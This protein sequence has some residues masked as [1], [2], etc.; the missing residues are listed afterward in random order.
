MRRDH[1]FLTVLAALLVALPVSLAGGAA[2]AA[3]ADRSSEGGVVVLAT[4]GS[5]HGI[6]AGT[7]VAKAGA[8]LLILTAAHVATFGVLELRLADASEVPARLVSVMPGRDLALIEAALPEN[9]AAQLQA[10]PLARPL[11]AEVVHVWGSGNDGPA[12]ETGTVTSVGRNL[13]D[14]APRGRYAFGCALCHEGDSGAGLFNER[15]ELVGVYIGYFALE[16]AR[17]SIAELPAT[18]VEIA[19]RDAGMLLATA[20]TA[21]APTVVAAAPSELADSR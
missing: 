10:A 2:Q 16:H 12:F 11:A 8:S 4:S 5:H 13:P 19:G 7:V 17:I 21:A 1:R 6:G 18:A 14:G 15:G 9:L 20:Q 3:E